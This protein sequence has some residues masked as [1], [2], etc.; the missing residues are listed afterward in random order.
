MIPLFVTPEHVS[1][2]PTDLP[3]LCT[4]P[5]GSGAMP[6]Q[7]LVQTEP[8]NPAPLSWHLNTQNLDALPASDIKFADTT[9]FDPA[10][11]L[12]WRKS[13]RIGSTTMVSSWGRACSLGRFYGVKQ[14]GL[15]DIDKPFDATQAVPVYSTQTG[16]TTSTAVSLMFGTWWQYD[17]MKLA[18]RLATLPSTF[19]CPPLSQWG[20]AKLDANPQN[21]MAHNLV[22]WPLGAPVPETGVDCRYV[23]EYA[24]QNRHAWA[25]CIEVAHAVI[26]ARIPTDSLGFDN[27]A[28]GEAFGVVGPHIRAGAMVLELLHAPTGYRGLPLDFVN[29]L[30]ALPHV[31]D[32]VVTR[33][34]VSY[35]ARGPQAHG[36]YGFWDLRSPSNSATAHFMRDR[37]P[38][39][40][41]ALSDPQAQAIGRRNPGGVVVARG[42]PATRVEDKPVGR[43]RGTTKAA[44]EARKA[45]SEV[46]TPPA[47]PKPLPPA[48]EDYFLNPQVRGLVELIRLV[49]THG[50]AIWDLYDAHPTTPPNP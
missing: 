22:P 4:F 39:V 49:E 5:G 6:A 2:A 25:Y 42:N 46:Q 34:N 19:I 1:F 32:F 17:I 31:C 9:A 28:L 24:R 7:W 35:P 16:A 44:L 40:F 43:P 27:V 30:P 48:L 38:H 8:L 33:D 41:T 15:L 11:Q 3:M 37:L 50:A 12:G 29:Y 21:V 10:M 13:L 45:Q 47:V 20:V 18:Q 14:Q 26:R 36:V 23:A